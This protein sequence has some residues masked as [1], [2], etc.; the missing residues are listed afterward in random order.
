MKSQ[1]I[2]LHLS[3]KLNSMLVL[4]L[5]IASQEVIPNADSK[6]KRYQFPFCFLCPI[7]LTDLALNYLG[8]F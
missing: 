7:L 8:S 2:F 6:I 5:C 4:F 1:K 3:F